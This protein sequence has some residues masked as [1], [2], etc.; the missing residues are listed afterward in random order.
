MIRVLGLMVLGFG[1]LAP[2][3]VTLSAAQE[4]HDQ[5]KHEWNDGENES[6]RRYL[7]ERHRKDHDWDR[8][9]K[10]ERSDYWKWRDKH[11]DDDHH[12]DHR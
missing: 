2:S 1:L 9:N 11:H 6:W 3:A 5:M 4:H 12:D 8:A 7:K 10:R